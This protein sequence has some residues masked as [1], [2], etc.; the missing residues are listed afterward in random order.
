MRIFTAIPLPKEVKDKFTEITRGRLPVP[1][2]NTTNFHITLNFFGELDTDQV[3]EVKK[4]WMNNFPT[5]EPIN[6]EFDKLTVFHQQIHLTLKP[7][8]ALNRLQSALEKNFTTIGFHFQD[9]EFYPHIKVS[10][11]HMD[12]VMNR[13]RKVVD[14]PNDL[15]S[16]LNFTADQI[17]LYE[18]KLLLHHPHHIEIEVHE[19]KR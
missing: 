11:L 4:I 14:F 3:V 19:L 7:N 8:S 6:I 2:V 17:G 16:Q 18:S 13:E 15:L 12:K 10:N 5:A 1:Y 9:R